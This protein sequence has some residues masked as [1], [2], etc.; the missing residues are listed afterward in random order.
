MVKSPMTIRK[1]IMW[2]CRHWPCRETDLEDVKVFTRV[3]GFLIP[4]ITWN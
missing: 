1:P 2:D 3:V 4:K